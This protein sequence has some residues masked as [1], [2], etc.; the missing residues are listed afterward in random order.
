[1]DRY[2]SLALDLYSLASVEPRVGGKS[3]PVLLRSALSGLLPGPSASVGI[4]F[5]VGRLHNLPDPGAIPLRQGLSLSA[6]LPR[7]AR[8]PVPKGPAG[9]LG[10]HLSGRRHRLEKG[11][12]RVF[13]PV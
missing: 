5:R 10:G 9:L 8:P 13:G 1:L 6:R 7:R 4:P 12:G 3:L 2:P 11:P